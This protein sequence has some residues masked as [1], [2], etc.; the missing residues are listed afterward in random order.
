MKKRVL[1]ALMASAM[2]WSAVSVSAL[3]DT[4]IGNTEGES[5][6]TTNGVQGNM[7]IVGEVSTKEHKE[8]FRVAVPTDKALGF[9]FIADP[10]KNGQYAGVLGTSD[11][12]K[13]TLYFRRNSQKPTW[14]GAALPNNNIKPI[15]NSTTWFLS[16]KSEY[17]VVSNIGSQD[18]LVTASVD[19]I[20]GNS[21]SKLDVGLE[22]YVRNPQ[23][24]AA[25]TSGSVAKPTEP[26]KPEKPFEPAYG[27][28]DDVIAE[29]QAALKAYEA[30][31]KKYEEVELPDYNNKLAIW[32][33]AKEQGGWLKIKVTNDEAV[34]TKADIIVGTVANK[35]N[36]LIPGSEQ[37]TEVNGSWDNGKWSSNILYN[38]D[39]SHLGTVQGDGSSEKNVDELTV[40][41]VRAGGH[42]LP[43]PVDK[44]ADGADGKIWTVKDEGAYY[45]DALTNVTLNKDTLDKVSSVAFQV[46]G[47]TS[48]NNVI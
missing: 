28:T 6:T 31:L 26:S 1:C 48:G 25:A 40:R 2:A 24:A 18:V 11:A 34:D 8:H 30:A 16:D 12:D 43:T 44:T 23:L 46:T 21:D 41:L 37:N 14:M 13:H 15:G 5:Q 17:L 22:A 4:N 38:S 45:D 7:S 10:E 33:A 32:N 3:A 42:V 35:E 9:A 29:Y 27:A 36:N 20:S 47:E 19:A 39:Q